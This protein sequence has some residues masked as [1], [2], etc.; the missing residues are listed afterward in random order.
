[1]AIQTHSGRFTFF[2]IFVGPFD[3][4]AQSPITRL[5]GRAIGF[6]E[7]DGQTVTNDIMLQASGSIEGTIFHADGTTIV[8]GAQVVLIPGGLSTTS[9]AQG[10]YRFDFVPVGF[11]T[12]DVTEL[13][14]GDRG[15]AGGTVT[16]Q[17]EVRIINVIMNGQGTVV[18]TVRDGA[19]AL[20]NEAQVSVI[21]L[22]IFG[23]TQGG[24]TDSS[25]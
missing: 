10:H 20:V 18:V 8:P 6:L 9:D 7:R 4:F 22:T 21:S 16:F 19:N 15:R 3:L 11:Y 24:V 17:D 1:M 13:S 14:T 5:A 25:G 12:V 23:G 2:N